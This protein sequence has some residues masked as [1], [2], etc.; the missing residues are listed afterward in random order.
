MPNQSFGRGKFASLLLLL[1]GLLIVL[2]VVFVGY[3]ENLLPEAKDNSQVNS[4]YSG[5]NLCQV[6]LQILC[7]LNDFISICCCIFSVPGFTCCG[8]YWIRFSDDIF[9]EIRI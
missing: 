6:S 3:D 4:K 1:Q 7:N 9:E 5:E 2:F 8:F